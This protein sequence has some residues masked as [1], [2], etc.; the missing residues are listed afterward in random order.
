QFV[1]IAIHYLAWSYYLVTTIWVHFSLGPR[2]KLI[3]TSVDGL[4][5]S[6]DTE[7]NIND[8]GHLEFCHGKLDSAGR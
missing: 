4:I 7:G 3:S 2:N 1:I 5:C 6:F 8:D